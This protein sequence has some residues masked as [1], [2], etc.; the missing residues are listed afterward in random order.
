MNCKI[1]QY[2]L[3]K[4]RIKESKKCGF[5]ENG[6]GSNDFDDGKIEMVERKALM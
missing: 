4:K 1:I 6:G 5:Q 2:N 3:I